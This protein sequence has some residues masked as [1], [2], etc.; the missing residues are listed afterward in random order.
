M[1]VEVDLKHFSCYLD[2]LLNIDAHTVYGYVI[3]DRSTKK[4]VILSYPSDNNKEILTG[5]SF[6]HGRF[7]MGLREQARRHG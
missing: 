2:S 6:H 7:I 1:A 3:H 4:N 5:R